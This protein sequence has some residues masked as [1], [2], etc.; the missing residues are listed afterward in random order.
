[1]AGD[2]D[3]R[4]WYRRVAEAEQHFEDVATTGGWRHARISPL[5]LQR[6]MGHGSTMFICV[7]RDPF[8]WAAAMRQNPSNS[9]VSPTEDLEIFVRSPWLASPRDELD[10]LFLNTPL[11]LWREKV[12]S[13]V[14][15]SDSEA[16]IYVIRYED[17]LLDAEGVVDRL[18]KFLPRV[19]ETV[20]LPGPKDEELGEKALAHARGQIADWRRDDHFRRETVAEIAD[21][22]G[23]SLLAE[24]DYAVPR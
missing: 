5:K 17:L 18:S 21:A 3:G 13:Y 9:F 22:I 2:S 19:S 4:R 24:L 7:S 20:Q 23:E 6:V 12:R 11:M 8:A 1:M 16:N 14:E 15:T 10:E